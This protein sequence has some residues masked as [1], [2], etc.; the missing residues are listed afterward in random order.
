M[1]FIAHNT[2]LPLYND[3]L[4]LFHFLLQLYS[5]YC[6]FFTSFDFHIQWQ[7]VGINFFQLMKVLKWKVGIYKKYLFKNSFNGFVY[8]A[9]RFQYSLLSKAQ[10]PLLKRSFSFLFIGMA[11]I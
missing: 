6:G 8:S 5:P 3:F 2:I 1:T 7:A 11:D 4:L 9:S 10:Y